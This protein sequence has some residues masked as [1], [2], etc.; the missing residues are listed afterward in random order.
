M[1]RLFRVFGG[2]REIFPVF[3]PTSWDTLPLF[4]NFL[5]KY[6]AV[7]KTLLTFADV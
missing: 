3:C 5:E 6:L 2:S 4:A 1:L 7:P